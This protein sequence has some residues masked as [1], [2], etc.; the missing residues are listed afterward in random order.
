[1][2]FARPTLTEIRDAAKADIDALLPGADSRLR[3]SVFGTLAT[4]MAAGIHLVHG[5]VAWA[6]TQL[7]PDTATDEFLERHAALQDVDRKPATFATGDV[8]LTGANAA[9]LPAGAVLQRSDGTEFTSD[10]V[11]VVAAGVAVVTVTASEAGV[12]G[13]TA[14]GLTLT[15]VSPAPGIDAAATVAVGG[16]VAGADTEDDDSLRSRLLAKLRE[17]PQGG[18]AGDYEKWALEIGGITRV[19]VFPLEG[20]PGKV[21]V[22]VVDDNGVASIAPNGAKIAEVQA[23]IDVRRPVTADVIVAAPVEVAMDFTIQLVPDTAATRAA[24]EQSLRDLLRRDGEPGALILISHIREAI[25]TA[26]GETDH[27]LTV[28][29]GDVAHAATQIAV[30]GVITW[31]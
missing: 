8:D 17:P 18:S 26:A 25:S 22:R 30:M 21:V 24:V 6:V 10:A 3:R 5:F 27:I 15:V 19:F 23:H 31:V 28:P 9:V 14:E 11:A 4:A 20:G 16:I 12:D 13:N 1:M 2:A 29:A 7:L